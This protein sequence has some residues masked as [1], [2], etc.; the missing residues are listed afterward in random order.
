MIE[1][2]GKPAYTHHETLLGARRHISPCAVTKA[3]SSRYFANVFLHMS[4]VT[5]DMADNSVV[6]HQQKAER[7]PGAAHIRR[8]HDGGRLKGRR[9]LYQ[10]LQPRRV[11]RLLCD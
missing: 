4:D 11:H 6:V 8:E 5:F 7:R 9:E 3:T 1:I 2:G 10:A